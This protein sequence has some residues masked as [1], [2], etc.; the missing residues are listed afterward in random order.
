[1]ATTTVAPVQSSL[2][3]ADLIARAGGV[4]KSD[5]LV[6]FDGHQYNG[7]GEFIEK[8]LDSIPAYEEA[9]RSE[10]EIIQTDTKFECAPNDLFVCATRIAKR[11]HGGISR[12]K[13]RGPFH[14]PSEKRLEIG[15]NDVGKMQYETV[16][17]D[18]FTL[19]GI[20]RTVAKVQIAPNGTPMLYVQHPRLLAIKKMVDGYLDFVR[21]EIANFS[22]YRGRV[23]TPGYEYV[24]VEPILSS[25]IIYNDDVSAVLGPVGLGPIMFPEALDEVGVDGKVGLCLA[26]PPGT[27]KTMF[28]RLETY[29]A[30]EH[31][32]TTIQIPS[33]GTIDDIEHAFRIARMYQVD[34][35]P[36]VILFEDIE[37]VAAMYDEQGRPNP[38]R[39]RLLEALDGMATKGQR[40]VFITTT[41]F[42][43]K[44]DG[45]VVRP[46]RIDQVVEMALPDIGAFRRLIELALGERLSDEVDWARAFPYFEG[47]TQAFIIKSGEMVLRAAVWRLQGD[48]AGLKIETDDL[49]SAALAYR[50][51]YEMQ[52]AAENRK[53]DVPLIDQAFRA[54][55]GDGLEIDVN[56]MTE[57][58]V[59]EVVDD[60]VENRLNQANIKLETERGQVVEG[61]LHTN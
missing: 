45:A 9:V 61:R 22:I 7:T 2:T 52:R 17:T 59:A 58:G 10:Y 44:L 40:I 60:V 31:G 15:F 57:A 16:P 23:I 36:A 54:L 43:D 47:Y 8:P 41:N 29:T 21:D 56:G 32:C 51:Q 39:P 6:T 11:M 35:K 20:D 46:G 33:G 5:Q 19:P 3:V 42:I 55:L 1:M 13:K 38:D 48:I 24:W 28:M 53:P 14:M 34:G 30:Q 12:T 27:G 18:W 49:I 50:R 25:E 26:G 4:M 37:R